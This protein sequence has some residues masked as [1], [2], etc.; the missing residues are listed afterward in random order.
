MSKAYQSYYKN[1]VSFF[2]KHPEF[3][4]TIHALGGIG[5]GI[6]VAN[7]LAK[8]H[9]VRWGLIFMALS[10]FGHVYAMLSGKRK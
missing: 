6:I 3:N 7:P 8:P 10:L 5:I 9:P 4:A 2:S 1:A